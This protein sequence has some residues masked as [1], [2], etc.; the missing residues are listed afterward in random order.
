MKGN[1]QFDVNYMRRPG[2]RVVSRPKNDQQMDHQM[3]NETAPGSKLELMYQSTRSLN[4]PLP[5]ACPGHLTSFPS[6]G[7][8]NL[9]NLVFPGAGHLITTHRGWGI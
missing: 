6:Q 4:I 9:V 8:G 7:G 1:I 3:M 2:Q 5:K